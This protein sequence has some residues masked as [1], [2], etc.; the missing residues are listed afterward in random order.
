MNN[1][2]NNS[3][4]PN[5]SNWYKSLNQSSLTPPSWVFPI[6]WTTL[7]ALIIASGIFFLTNGGGI[8]S[9]GF[10]YYCVAWVLNFS[11]SLAFFTYRRSDISFIIILGMVTF[12]ALNIRAFY[13]VNRIAGF[14]LVPYLLWVSLATYLNGYI[15]FMNTGPR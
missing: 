14:L 3:T 8:R 10:L 4:S 2:K 9:S 7:Y 1:A 5:N 11:W 12:I 15:L 13:T 6:V